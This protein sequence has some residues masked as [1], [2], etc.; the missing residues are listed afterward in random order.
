MFIN[1]GPQQVPSL[2][3]ALTSNF[4]NATNPL[5]SFANIEVRGG[6]A[7]FADA[8]DMC[9]IPVRVVQPQTVGQHSLCSLVQRVGCVLLCTSQQANYTYVLI[10][11]GN[12]AYQGLEV[13]ADQ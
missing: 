7:G 10:P 9:T 2:G 4:T 6:D 3:Q 12:L 1:A 8:L 5:D 13:R 11:G